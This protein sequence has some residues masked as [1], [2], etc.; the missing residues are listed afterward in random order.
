MQNVYYSEILLPLFNTDMVHYLYNP[1]WNLQSYRQFV[2]PV[3]A[4]W[5]SCSRRYLI[6]F[7]FQSMK[8][9]PETR[10]VH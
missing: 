5:Y 4:L 2:F 7:P 8:V 6:Y 10:C 3:K 9:I 1:S